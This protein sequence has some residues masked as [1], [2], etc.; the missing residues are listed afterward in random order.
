MVLV[1]NPYFRL[2]FVTTPILFELDTIGEFIST[3]TIAMAPKTGPIAPSTLASDLAK[4]SIATKNMQKKTDPELPRHDEHNIYFDGKTFKRGKE[5]P[6][7]RRDKS[8]RAWYWKH[9]EEITEDKKKFWMCTRCW[10][11]KEPRFIIFTQYSNKSIEKHLDE[12][13]NTTEK[14]RLQVTPADESAFSIPSI[15]NWE[16]LKLRLIEWV[17]VMHI[18]FSQVENDWFRRFLA[19]LSPS[20]EQWIPRAG[21]TVRAW[22]LAEFG[23]RQEEIREGLRS[24]KSRIHLSFD[25]WTSPNNI[26]FVGVVGHYMSSQ[27]KVET[28]LLGLRRLHGTHSGENIAEAVVKI[29]G[30]YGLT[31]DQVG[32]FVLDNASSNDTCV[33]EIIKA[34]GINDTVEHR[35]L[36]C[37]GH[38]INLAAK[39]FFFGSDSTSFEDEIEGTQRREDDKKE[40]AIWRKQGPI[41]KLHNIVKYILT[42][43]QR[44]EEFEE[45]VRGEIERQKDYLRDTAQ[46]DE[47][48]E[49][50]IKYPLTVI[51]DNAT[52]WNS[53]FSMI[54]RAFLLKDPLD[55]FVKRA[56][57]KPANA[58]PLPE[59]DELLAS[60]WNVLARARDILQPFYDLTLALQGR[61]SDAR[62]GSIWEA[63]PALDFLLNGLD[64][65]S[66][67]Y[68]TELTEASRPTKKTTNK[69]AKEKEVPRK[70][71]DECATTDIMHISTSIASCKAK[72]RKYRTLMDESPIYVAALVLNPEHKLD[73]FAINWENDPYLIAEAQESVEDLWLTMYKYS[74]AVSKSTEATEANITLAESTNPGIPRQ[75]PP[76]KPSEFDQWISRSKYK[77]LGSKPMVDEYQEYL[78][79]E[80]SPDQSGSSVDLCAFWAQN[81]AKYPSLARMAF[82]VLSIPAMSAECERVFSS[83]KILLSDRRARMKEDIVEASECL[84]AWLQS[85]QCVHS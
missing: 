70:A 31:G 56:L 50:V 74:L 45:K 28:T 12:M 38:I 18:T 80:H 32:W 30:K 79:T 81:E 14:P 21:N 63:L 52:R 62:H 49:A 37:L 57:E 13:H 25:L 34:L 54:V 73:Y 67:E 77:S 5:R 85:G 72:L 40:R 20:L 61:A 59:E 76:K 7:T 8:P 44:R 4:L 2:N 84:R 11:D 65:K 60:D 33:K 43:P 9:A 22:I 47:D 82:D 16:R 39:A 29:I 10:E 36:R 51:R 78:K 69:K 58:S 55:L 27:Y 19:A 71:S 35:R 46:P 48:V 42:T 41:G 6:A 24:S 75:A 83:S 53:V 3:L 23:R 26:A 15:F 17:V 64:M 66:K 68:S 1:E